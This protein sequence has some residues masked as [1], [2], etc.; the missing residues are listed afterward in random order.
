M[1]TYRTLQIELVHF[2]N[3]KRYIKN[4]ILI[5]EGYEFMY[6][7]LHPNLWKKFFLKSFNP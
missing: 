7:N 1:K 4:S 5:M 6:K 2:K 3:D